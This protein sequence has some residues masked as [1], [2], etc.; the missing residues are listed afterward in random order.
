MN[1][2][3]LNIQ[4][5][6]VFLE[7]DSPGQEITTIKV[8]FTWGDFRTTIMIEMKGRPTD[9]DI[10]FEIKKRG[11]ELLARDLTPVGDSLSK[12]GTI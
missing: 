8:N 6:E 7:E 4:T 12:K 11:T 1:Y 3:I 10:L 2:E 9:D 5:V